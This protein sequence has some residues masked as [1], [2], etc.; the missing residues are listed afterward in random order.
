MGRT[1]R[2]TDMQ[3]VICGWIRDSK[4]HYAPPMDHQREGREG[5]R[6]RGRERLRAESNIYEAKSDVDTSF[7]NV[8][9]DSMI[10]VSYIPYPDTSRSIPVNKS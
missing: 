2:Q 8:P 10:H 4:L 3:Y 9:H 7:L 1:D 6:V 5:K